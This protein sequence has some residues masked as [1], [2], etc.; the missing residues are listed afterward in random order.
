MSETDYRFRFD[1]S[2]V[3]DEWISGEVCGKGDF[4]DF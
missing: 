1:R 3:L 2:S 4:V